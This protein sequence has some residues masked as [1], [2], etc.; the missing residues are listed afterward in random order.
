MPVDKALTRSRLLTGIATVV[1]SGATI[2]VAS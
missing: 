2:F 1:L